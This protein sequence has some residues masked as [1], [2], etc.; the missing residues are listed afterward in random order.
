MM[1]REYTGCKGF[2]LAYTEEDSLWRVIRVTE[3][4]LGATSWSLLLG[5]LSFDSAELAMEFVRK[6]L[7]N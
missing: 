6:Q 3:M 1:R 4:A 7:V 2:L 5:G